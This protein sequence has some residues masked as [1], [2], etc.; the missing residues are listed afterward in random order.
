L[1]VERENIARLRTYVAATFI[2]FCV[3]AVALLG[4]TG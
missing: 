3:I 4:A 2:V 1:G